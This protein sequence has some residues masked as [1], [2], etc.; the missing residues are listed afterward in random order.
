MADKLNWFRIALELTYASFLGV[1]MGFITGAIYG[2]RLT[3]IAGGIK[4]LSGILFGIG[5][6]CLVNALMLKHLRNS[7]KKE[8]GDKKINQN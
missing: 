3:G 7:I 8:E 1:P 4:A 5:I 6:G 2:I